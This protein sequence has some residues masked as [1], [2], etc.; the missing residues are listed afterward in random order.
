RAE[1][2]P[3]VEALKKM[4]ATSDKLFG[5][6]QAI[7]QITRFFKEA[8]DLVPEVKKLLTSLKQPAPPMKEI[9]KMEV[10]ET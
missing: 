9:N 4:L 2:S 10:V 1:K 5:D 3:T 8:S 6:D 7:E